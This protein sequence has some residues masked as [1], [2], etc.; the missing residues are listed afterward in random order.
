[1]DAEEAPGRLRYV[2]SPAVRLTGIVPTVAAVTFQD[3]PTASVKTTLPLGRV[4]DRLSPQGAIDVVQ[5]RDV[6]TT[7][8][9]LVAE[10]TGDPRGASAKSGGWRRDRRVVDVGEAQ[11]MVTPQERAAQ[12]VRITDI[13]PEVEGGA[14]AAP[15]GGS[16]VEVL[17]Q[18]A[19]D[20]IPLSSRRPTRGT[21]AGGTACTTKWAAARP[22]RCSAA[23]TA[24]PSSSPRS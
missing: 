9:Y 4:P 23:P 10:G 11:W 6:K 16:L 2:R 24:N 19:T 20:V 18:G 7:G 21:A 14:C 13:A 1:M 12:Q 5:V 17:S 15:L 8:R 3:V 22:R